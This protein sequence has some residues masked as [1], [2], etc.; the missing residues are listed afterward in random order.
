M[1]IAY[2]ILGHSNPRALKRLLIS[3]TTQNST[4]FVHIDKKVDFNLE[5]INNIHNVVVSDQRL[6]LNWGG[7]SIVAATLLLL[8][9]AFETKHFD[10]YVLISGDSYPLKSTKYI[11]QFFVRNKKLEFIN[12][13]R[14][15]GVGKTLDRFN[16]YLEYDPRRASITGLLI[17]L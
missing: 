15:P 3:L 7:Y 10:R 5:L 6:S 4:C 13:V 2:L 8:K 12:C 16:F 11:E 9:K 17:S 1:N 14:M